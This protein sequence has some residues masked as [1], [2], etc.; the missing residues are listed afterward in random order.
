VTLHRT[1]EPVALRH[2]RP[3]RGQFD[4]PR[5]RGRAVVALPLGV[6]AGSSPRPVA[7][8]DWTRRSHLADV[9]RRFRL[10]H[11]SSRPE[12]DC[13]GV[14]WPAR[15]R[16]RFRFESDRRGRPTGASA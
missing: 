15:A 8:S 2:S 16:S 1:P 4:N 12:A 11:L 3:D 6:E 10:D 9:R 7:L 14:P 13:A 5:Q